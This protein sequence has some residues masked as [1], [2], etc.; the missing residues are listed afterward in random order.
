MKNYEQELKLELTQSQF[1]R[2]TKG[3][4]GVVQKNYYFCDLK[5]FDYER[6]FRIREKNGEFELTYKKRFSNDNGIGQCI[7]YNC[8]I[9]SEQARIFFEHGI[10]TKVFL[11]AFGINLEQ[12]RFECVGCLT[13][14]RYKVPFF[15]YLLE[16]DKNDYLSKTDFELECENG[17][18]AKLEQLKG[19]LRYHFGI[20]LNFAKTKVE[21]FFNELNK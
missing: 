14:T 13:T 8:S 3:F 12:K 19:L 15:E 17:D 6:C 20:K 7:E 16:I 1:E 9:S 10:D 5:D 4:E 18:Y 11:T 21:R 2:I